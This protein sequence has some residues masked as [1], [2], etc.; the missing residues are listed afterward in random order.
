MSETFFNEQ[1]AETHKVEVVADPASH[2]GWHLDRR[3]PGA[4]ILAVM[5]QTAGIVW[6]AATLSASNT[7]NTSSI[8][9][10]K[11]MIDK[12]DDRSQKTSNDMAEVKA[13]VDT[14]TDTLSR[15]TDKL[16]TLSEKISSLTGAK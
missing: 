4:L 14:M 15:Q 8:T 6:W 13:K 5:L 11:F 10:N 1:Q 12:L 16:D 2:G 9:A 3:I 7:M